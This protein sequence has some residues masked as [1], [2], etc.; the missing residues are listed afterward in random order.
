MKH[1]FV[2]KGYT[3]EQIAAY[4]LNKYKDIRKDEEYCSGITYV[5]CL[6][7][8]EGLS[9]IDSICK[10][11]SESYISAYYATSKRESAAR[12][13]AAYDVSKLLGINYD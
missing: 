7:R 8:D 6:M 11:L 13:L 5:F 1:L 2:T 12:F 3:E 10:C 9:A 4:I